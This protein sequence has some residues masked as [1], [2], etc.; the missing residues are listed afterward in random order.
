VDGWCSGIPV[1]MNRERSQLCWGMAIILLLLMICIAQRAFSQGTTADD[2]ARLEA[3]ARELYDRAEYAKGALLA[4]RAVSIW[5]ATRGE[6][7]ELVRALNIRAELQR[8]L[9]NY[10][11]A[12]QIFERALDISKRVLGPEHA[13]T[14]EALSGLGVVY[15]ILGDQKRAE[16]LHL[17]ALAIRQKIFGPQHV[18][19]ALSYG[20]VGVEYLITGNYK[21]AESALQRAVDIQERVLG[22]HVR[23][24]RS[25]E[26]LANLYQTIEA[27]V[28]AEKLYLRAIEIYTQLNGPNHPDV[29]HALSN[30]ASLYLRTGAYP[31]AAEL[32]RR[33][34]A[35]QEQA[36]GSDHVELAH[37]LINLASAYDLQG[38]YARAKP[39]FERALR[40]KERDAGRDHISTTTALF[41]LANLHV[42][43]GEY[44]TAEALHL[45]VLRVREKDLGPEHMDVASSLSDLAKL[46]LF[47]GN[48]AKAEVLLQRALRI[49]E[50][51]VG[52]GHSYAADTLMS[53][54]TLYCARGEPARALPLL[55]R[56]R[57][58][59]A[60]NLE[61]F[62]VAGSEARKQ[63]YLASQAQTVPQ[64]VSFSLAAAGPDSAALGLLSVLDY[65]GRALD[66]FADGMTRLR[67]NLQADD[68][69]IFAELADVAGQL[70]MLG[71]Q[72]AEDL[73]AGV[74]RQRA[75]DLSQRQ[76]ALEAKL[77]A[78][79]SEFRRE[80]ATVTLPAVQAAIPQDAVLVE[81]FKYAPFKPKAKTASEQWGEPRYVA[82]VLKYSG[83]PLAFDVGAARP[84]EAAVGKLRAAVSDP[85]RQ[86]VRVPATTLYATLIE[87]LRAHLQ[88]VR[89]LLLS[90]DAALTF[91]PM[92]ALVDAQGHYLVER[93]EITYLTSGRDLLRIAASTSQRHGAASL[94]M[95]DPQYGP[96]VRMPAREAGQER[97]ADLDRSGLVF[98]SLPGTALEAR[99]ITDL[100]GKSSTQLLTGRQATEANLKQLHGPRILHLAT[101]GFFLRDPQS[102]APP[103]RAV[104]QKAVVQQRSSLVLENPLLR[105]GLALSGANTRRSGTKDDGILTALEFAR[106]DLQG[107]QLVVLSACETGLGEMSTGEGVTGLRR[108]VLLAGA[109][110]QIASL[111]R[112][113]DLPTQQLMVEFYRRLVKGSGRS[114]ALR[115]AQLEMLADPARSHPYYWASFAAIGDW[116]PLPAAASPRAPATR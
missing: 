105:S 101:H 25:V 73:P 90:P 38:D 52:L 112:V 85:A 35:I 111:W 86:D 28:L 75:A 69:A 65:K 62:I 39:L 94:V 80:V 51:S 17:Q 34:V 99:M 18:T 36:L 21:K 46:Y 6:S 44:A 77:A 113:A 76:D 79:S 74:Y 72:D 70:S 50:R 24:A 93:F 109:Q 9:G 96:V 48:L 22:A 67:K 64:A 104:A 58:I 41:Y 1:S 47:T 2:A 92:A 56:A 12:T 57:L 91:A 108:G 71:F 83:A 5:E 84:I 54:A 20:D 55:Q 53:L 13:Q 60:N 45:R 88:G 32:A 27:H 10:S 7:L 100:L 29:A 107:T 98:R 78:R 110:T 89:R 33:A 30:L 102:E 4:Q 66:A 59:N 26:N 31:K 42:S 37:P 63:E 114:A 19:T 103:Q 97:S 87:P 81:W 15:S 16:P 23:T 8:K 106:I 40:I 49:Y 95:A 82:Y 61:R 11:A 14:A 116:R 3:E 115:G 68:R 43:L